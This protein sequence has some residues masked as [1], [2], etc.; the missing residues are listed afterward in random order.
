VQNEQRPVVI[1][2]GEVLWDMLPTGKQF[3]G[4]PANFAYHARVLGAD[5]IVVSA[6]G[7][8][9]LGREILDRIEGL[10]LS[11]KYVA[12]DPEHPTGTVSVEVDARGRPDYIIHQGVAWDFI[13]AAPELAELAAGTDAVCFGSLAQRGEVSRGTIRAFLAATRPDCLRIFDINLRQDFFDVETITAGLQAA[14]VVK[15]NDEELP[16]VA[17]LLQIDV[18]E[19]LAIASLIRQY[20][21]KVVALTRGESGSLLV[22]PD[23]RS[24][25]PGLPADVADTVGAGDCFTA[26]L[27]VGLLQQLDLESINDRANRAA[28]YVCSRHGA[29]PAMPDEL[30]VSGKN[31]CR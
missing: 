18:D 25:H 15:L 30:T 11:R 8:D 5:A 16:A 12:V 31:R 10:G 4:A 22:G 3:G 26:V 14:N 17:N 29:T 6:V 28:C 2:L 20:G 19:D 27:A 7:N 9:D 24:E 23:A 21:L 1:G 13:P